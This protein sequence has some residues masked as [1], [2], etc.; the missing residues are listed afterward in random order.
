MNKARSFRW[1]GKSSGLRRGLAASV[2]LCFLVTFF[3]SCMCGPFC[4]EAAAG[5][6]D[7]ACCCAPDQ[8]EAEAAACCQ[9]SGETGCAED[10]A[11][12][13]LQR[14]DSSIQVA[15]PAAVI[16]RIIF[17]ETEEPPRVHAAAGLV[18]RAHAPPSYLR[19]Q[20]FLI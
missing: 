4:A 8:A 17:F 15:V 10:I 2:S 13:V 3:I 6:I 20:S 12:D 18:P 19:F 7:A 9:E 11:E 14:S 1:F 16:C 5:G